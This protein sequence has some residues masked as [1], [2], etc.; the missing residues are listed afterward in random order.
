[1]SPPTASDAS[2]SRLSRRRLLATA[3]M[4]ATL[5]AGGPPLA[6]AQTPAVSPVATNTAGLVDIGGRSLYLERR[7]IGGPTVVF[8][9]GYRSP[10]TV[11]TDDLVQPESPR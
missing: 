9:A 1:M 4:S 5:L 11:W 10:A 3:A 2:P 7:G 8:E 6:A